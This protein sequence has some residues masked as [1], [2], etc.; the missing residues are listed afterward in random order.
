M[1][2]ASVRMLN[3]YRVVYL[4]KHPRCMT[5]YNW[6]GY[7]YEHIVVAEKK[8]KR[9]LKDN[10]C[11]HHKNRIRDDNRPSNLEVMTKEAHAAL[12]AEDRIKD[13]PPK[14]PCARCGAEVTTRQNIYCSYKCSRIGARVVERPSKAE[15][16]KL[17]STMP[18]TRIGTRYGVSDNAVRKWARG[19]GLL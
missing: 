9:R 8:I 12:H 18:W 6:N 4:P 3:G 15:L 14:P 5:S 17:I 16:K 10:E 7:I 11:V 2:K 19:Y 13:V 1:A